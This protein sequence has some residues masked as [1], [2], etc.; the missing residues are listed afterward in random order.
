MKALLLLIL[1]LYVSPQVSGPN[2]FELV[3]TT[4]AHNLGEKYQQLICNRLRGADFNDDQQVN[5]SDYSVLYRIMTGD[6]DSYLDIQRPMVQQFL[7]LN[8]DFH[9]DLPIIN[10]KDLALFYHY[11]LNQIPYCPYID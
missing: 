10:D 6:E 9:E 7:N 11:L 8:G 5:E 3:A 2:V 1:L 4:N